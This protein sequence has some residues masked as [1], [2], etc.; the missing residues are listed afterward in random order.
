M[1]PCVAEKGRWGE[2]ERGLRTVR[3]GD[4]PVAEVRGD[5]SEGGGI[6]QVWNK[7]YESAGGKVNTRREGLADDDGSTDKESGRAHV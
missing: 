1:N 6:V 2:E 3:P 7:R 4:E 5:D